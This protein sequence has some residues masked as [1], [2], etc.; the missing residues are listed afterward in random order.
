MTK[1][2]QFDLERFINKLSLIGKQFDTFLNCQVVIVNNAEGHKIYDSHGRVGKIYKM[3]KVEGYCIAGYRTRYKIINGVPHDYGTYNVDILY[4]LNNR[5][6][7]ILPKHVFR[8][9]SYSKCEDKD[10]ILAYGRNRFIIKPQTGEYV[11]VN[12]TMVQHIGLEK[13]FDGENLTIALYQYNFMGPSVTVSYD[14]KRTDDQK[15]I[16]IQEVK[17]QIYK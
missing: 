11:K 9:F 17:R 5:L 15:L 12:T 13:L 4:L 3:I 7:H 1:S 8:N 10:V 2:N 14:L 6:V 16:D